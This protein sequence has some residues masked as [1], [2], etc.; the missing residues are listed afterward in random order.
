MNQKSGIHYNTPK[1]R[2]Q[3]KKTVGLILMSVILT[4]TQMKKKIFFRVGWYIFQMCK[5]HTDILL[6]QVVISTAK[7]AFNRSNL[8]QQLW[9]KKKNS[10]KKAAHTVSHFLSYML[11]ALF[12]H[13]LFTEKLLVLYVLAWVIYYWLRVINMTCLCYSGLCAIEGW[14]LCFVTGEWG[15]RTGLVNDFNPGRELGYH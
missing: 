10:I 9:W 14:R 6:D 5:Q 4:V 15:R 8:L 1:I 2:E 3:D 13:W 11:Q 7:L 12:L